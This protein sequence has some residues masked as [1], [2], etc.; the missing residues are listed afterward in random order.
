MHVAMTL[1]L[2]L[3]GMCSYLSQYSWNDLFTYCLTADGLWNFFCKVLDDAL[4]AFVPLVLVSDLQHITPYKI[5]RL[6]TNNDRM[7]AMFVAPSQAYSRNQDLRAQ[8]CKICAECRLVIR[9]FEL[10]MEQKVIVAGSSGQFLIT[11]TKGWADHME[12]AF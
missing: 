4:G 9:Q 6:Y 2:M 1:M 11:L 7:E 8:Y 10:F 12:L 3:K 5:S